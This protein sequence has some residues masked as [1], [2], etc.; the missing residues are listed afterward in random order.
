[1]GDVIITEECFQELQ[2]IAKTPETEL[3]P[4][5]LLATDLIPEGWKVVEDVA[6]SDFDV[7]KLVPINFIKNSDKICSYGISGELLRKRAVKSGSNLGLADGKRILAEPDKLSAEFRYYIVPLPG[8]VL[9]DKFGRLH[10]AVL[11][12]AMDGEE[13]PFV[14]GFDALDKDQGWRDDAFRLAGIRP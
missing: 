13:E 10:I 5:A 2:A 4:S 1:M 14:L 7:S 3:F 11:F 12:A 8:T 6:P 9:Q